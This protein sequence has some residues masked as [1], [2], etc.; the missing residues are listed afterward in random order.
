MTTQLG[1]GFFCLSFQ[2]KSAA[3]GNKD[4]SFK[5]SPA[6][7]YIMFPPGEEVQDVGAQARKPKTPTVPT[8]SS[9]DFHELSFSI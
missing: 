9:K 4:A 7:D 5:A 2:I 1:I 8:T 3:S 6:L